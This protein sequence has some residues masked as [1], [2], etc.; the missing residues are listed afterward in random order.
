[1]TIPRHILQIALGDA[2]IARLPL[3][4]LRS[5]LLTK[6]PTYTYTFWTDRECRVFLEESFPE[7][8][9]LYEQLER[10]QYKSDL[11]RYLY[12]YKH[13]GFYVDIDLYL[14]TPFDELQHILDCDFFIPLGA[15]HG[16]CL[17]VA[18]GFMGAAP[19]FLLF[20]KLVAEMARNP[21][22]IDYGSN[23]KTFR[24]LLQETGYTSAPFLCQDRVVFLREFGPLLGKYYIT[25]DGNTI[26]CLSN[27]HGYPHQIPTLSA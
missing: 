27:G 20:P 2:Y 7:H 11:I 18:N 8:M 26:A 10:V 12:L 6:N 4:R 3:E 1:M 9:P 14:L 25:A 16:G 17:E 19:G 13:G 24:R 21:N 5:H 15:H 22:P 23:V